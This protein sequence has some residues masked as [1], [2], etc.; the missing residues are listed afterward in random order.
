MHHKGFLSMSEQGNNRLF[1]SIGLDVLEKQF[2][3]QRSK[4]N[5]MHQDFWKIQQEHQQ[6]QNKINHRPGVEL[7][8]WSLG[9]QKAYQ[10]ILTH[11]A[12]HKL[13]YC[14]CIA[15]KTFESLAQNN[16]ELQILHTDFLDQLQKS[17]LQVHGIYA[18]GMSLME[19]LTHSY[20]FDDLLDIPN[21][22]NAIQIWITGN[23]VTT[24]IMKKNPQIIQIT[25]HELANMWMFLAEQ[26]EKSMK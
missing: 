18:Q 8:E 7:Y 17:W 21:T 6:L 9:M 15:S 26:L 13:I 16:K 1:A 25:S 22:N 11:L 2:Q 5:E 14:H 12:E 3:Q 4:L 24:F 20:H 10:H 23:L 19:S